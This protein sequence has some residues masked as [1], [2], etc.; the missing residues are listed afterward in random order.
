V[1]EPF[2]FFRETPS[3][4]WDPVRGGWE[5]FYLAY[6]QSFFEDPALGQMQSLDDV[7]ADWPATGVEIY[8]PTPGAWDEHFLTSPNALRGSDGV[9]R[10]YYVGASFA[11]DGGRAAVGLLTSTDGR[12]WE[13]HPDNPVFEGRPGEWDDNMLD[14]GVRFVE[15]RYLM[16]YS[17]YRGE[18][19]VVPHAIGLAESEDGITWRRVDDAPIIEHGAPGTWNDWTVLDAEVFAEPDGSLVLTAYGK[20]YTPTYPESPDFLPGRIGLWRSR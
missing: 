9:W 18:V 14:P 7:G 2:D 19:Q 20:T 8:R 15:G 12:S 1:T 10:L 4:L 5:M 13:P 17:A 16:W 6:T 11:I 3:V